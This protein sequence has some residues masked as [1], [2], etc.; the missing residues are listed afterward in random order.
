MLW[1]YSLNHFSHLCLHR[2][3]NNE[4]VLMIVFNW[5]L[6]VIWAI[7][8]RIATQQQ[9]ST[10]SE[11]FSNECQFNVVCSTGKIRYTYFISLR[12]WWWWLRAM[13]ESSM[14]QY[15]R[16]VVSTWFMVQC[17]ATW[18]KFVPVSKSHQMKIPPVQCQQMSYKVTKLLE[19]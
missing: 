9:H 15:A 8:I 3:T 2:T 1:I 17:T 7:F 5:I 11:Y 16:Y 14:Q 12:N 19:L 10:I 13:R 6:H 4:F 18:Y